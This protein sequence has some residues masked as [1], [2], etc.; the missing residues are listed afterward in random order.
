[1]PSQTAIE[2]ANARQNIRMNKSI[3]LNRAFHLT[4]QSLNPADVPVRRAAKQSHTY[5]TVFCLILCFSFFI[6]AQTP[7]LFAQK[8]QSKADLTPTF[9]QRDPDADFEDEGRMHCA[10]TAVSDGLIYLARAFGITDLVP[11]TQ[12]KE[13]Q[14]E[15]IEELAEHFETDPGVGGTNPDKILTGLQSYMESKGYELNRLE[16]M[17]WRPVSNA[18]KKFKIGIKPEISWMRSAARNKDTVMIF[19]FGWYYET[20][21]GYSRKGGHW[22]AV[23]GATSDTNEFYIHNPSLRSAE[24]AAK[25]SVMLSQLDEDFMVVDYGGQKIKAINMKGYYDSEGP[26]LPRGKS[27]EAAILDA[28]IVFSLKK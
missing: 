18:N 27:M 1:M 3:K 4:N 12:Q 10:P 20:E 21:D 22:V 8:T 14:I 2:E 5:K 25:K 28:V 26:G 13:G 23:V 9:W 17:S 11:S 16:L 15:L 7:V 24:Q 19:N 6:S